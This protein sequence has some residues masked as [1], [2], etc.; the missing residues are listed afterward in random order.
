MSTAPA[1]G[2]AAS[3]ATVRRIQVD[4]AKARAPLD[5]AFNFSVG[6]DYPGTLNRPASLAQL[7][8]AASE[9]GFRY[10]RFHA[11]FHDVLGTVRVE[12][13]KTVYDWGK[14]DALYD[15]F[16]AM[17]IRPFVELGFTPQVMAT[18]PQTIFYWK[19]NTSHPEPKAWHAL[20]DAFVRHLIARY[21]AAEVR[22]WYFEVW[23]EP[24]LAGFWEKADQKAYFELY[25]N[26]AR[27]IKAID[28]RLRVG[29]PS[30]AGAAWVPEM[31]GFAA[32]RNVPIDFV[33]THT[34]G[35][36][37]G[38][39]DE[40]GQDDNKLSTNPDAVTADVRRVR[41]Q[42]A[43]SKFPNL[44]LY[45]T[46]WSSSYNPRDPV[47]DS[48]ISAAY[49]LDKLKAVR[50]FAQGMS[51]WTYS[52][53]FEEAGPPPT[54]FHGGF[55]L[56]TRD[57]IRKSAWFA[58][59]YLNELRGREVPSGDGETLIATQNGRTAVLL[60][61]W[62]QPE[63]NVSNRPFFTKPIPAAAAAAAELRF[64]GLAP[65]GYRL[66][67]RRTGYQAN[68]AYTRYLEMGSPLTVDEAQRAELQNL[69]RD[70]PEKDLIVRV[71]ATGRYSWPVPMRANDVILA[72]LEPVRNA[73]RR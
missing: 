3:P 52:D 7:R 66:T 12:E 28:P 47:H 56:M 17:G 27:A 15:A 26:S 6:A 40:Y 58:Y 32:A 64:S 16:H 63:Q 8:V 39:L 25:E 36:D 49:I 21:G 71:N 44:P 65:G 34:Y 68:D 42:I 22:R 19:G 37:A 57:G 18:S 51:Y 13:D 54:P 60:W 2:Q 29:G 14:I 73:R 43:A 41:R 31:L 67:V 72:V 11:V 24:N 59:K 61:D 55:G 50:G 5:R 4:I 53:L 48:Y 62:R 70:L 1:H 35:V 30:T 20:V 38:F 33:T 45:F 23:N 9:L 46:E 10:I 69:T